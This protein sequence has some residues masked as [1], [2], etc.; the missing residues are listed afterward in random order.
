MRGTA[1]TPIPTRRAAPIRSTASRSSSSIPPRSPPSTRTTHAI[2]Y[3]AGANPL[4]QGAIIDTPAVGDLDG[5]GHPEIV[6]GTN[7]E[8]SE[9]LNLGNP[10]GLA[11]PINAG[12]VDP[13]NSRIYAIKSSGG[14]D[15]DPLPTDALLPGWPFDVGMLLTETLPIVGE[16]ITG[17]PVIGPV[18]CADGGAGNKVGTATAAGPAYI[19]N[20]DGTSCYGDTSGK[21]N[22]LS[23]DFSHTATATDSPVIPTLG[24]P[25]FGAAG[26]SSADQPAFIT[27]AIGLFRALDLQVTEYQGGQDLIGVWDAAS[28][29][30]KSRLPGDR[31]R[32]PAAHRA[33]RRRHRRQCRRGGPDRKRQPGPRR[34]RPRRRSAELALAEADHG[35]DRRDAADRQLRHRRHRGRRR[36]R[37]SSASPGPATSTPTGPMPRPARPLPRR[38]STMTTPTPATIRATRSCRARRPGS[39]P[40]STAR[41]SASTLPATTCSAAPPTITSW[42]R[43]ARRSTSRA[44]PTPSRSPARRSPPRPGRRRASSVPKGS[45]GYLAIR[46]VDEQGN[47]GRVASVKAKAPGSGSKGCANPINGTSSADHLRGTPAGDDIT[48]PRPRRSDRGARRR[49]LHPRRQAAPTSSTATTA[50]TRSEAVPAAIA[51]SSTTAGRTASRAAAAATSLRR[52]ARTGSTTAAKRS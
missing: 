29:Q 22:A 20:P 19:V 6:V 36:P 23:S 3:A 28:G 46:A 40:P 33:G 31:E 30:F 12:L 11:L 24:N 51:S 41:G 34:L 37:W 15:A 16:G 21:A 47:V 10:G 27:A 8:Y 4:M 13:G 39:G 42:S 14:S 52:I 38:A 18:D 48:R 2:T 7:E 45:K 25:A 50:R 26:G 17:P 5:D 43:P 44:S 32:S 35:L 49:R 9:D 1:P